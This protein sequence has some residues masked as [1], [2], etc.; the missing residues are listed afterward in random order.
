MNTIF[1]RGEFDTNRLFTLNPAKGVF[2]VNLINSQPSISNSSKI[3][4]V[5]ESNIVPV[6]PSIKNLRI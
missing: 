4:R 2:I 3:I 1:A 5:D 6:V